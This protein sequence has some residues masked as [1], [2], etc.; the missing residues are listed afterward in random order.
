MTG[1]GVVLI[2]AS[3]DIGLAIADRFA[4]D[5]DLVVGVSLQPVAHSALAAHLE[6][7]CATAEGATRVVD[8]ALATAGRLD[9]VVLAAAYQPAARLTDMTDEQWNGSVDA[10]LGT[11]F[12]VCRAALPHLAPGSA[13]VAVSSVNGRVAAP[14]LP[15]YAAA[16][17]GLEGLVRQLAL[18]YGPQGVR[19]NAVVP[20]MITTDAQ[21]RPE[22]AAGY[23]LCRTGRPPEVAEVVHFLAGDGASFVTGVSLPV[24]GGLTIASPAA[25]ARADLRDRF[26]R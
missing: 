23:P 25:F 3:S 11:A 4:R 5:G 21:D 10:V 9:V 1:R 18:D 19:V 22:L 2:G 14:W 12:Q 6:V 17:A 20:G 24:D 15:S 7:D 26:L 13:I 8:T 16:K